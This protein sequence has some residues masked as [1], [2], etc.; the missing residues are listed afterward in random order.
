MKSSAI[1]IKLKYSRNKIP[2][3]RI[4]DHQDRKDS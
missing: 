3:K 4:R 1:S 2:F